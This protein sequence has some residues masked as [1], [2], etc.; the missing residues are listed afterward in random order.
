M[1]K[2]ANNN[3]PHSEDI[4]DIISAPPSALLRWG[5]TGVFFV[6]LLIVGLSA[7]IRY[8]DIVQATVRISSVDAPKAVISKLSGTIV[9]LLVEENEKVAKG[10]ALAWL[11]STADHEQVITLLQELS[12][13]RDTHLVAK[14]R[15]T[16]P[17]NAPTFQN[18]GELQQ[19]YQ[20]FYQA[21]ISLQA[22]VEGGIL[23]KRKQYLHRDLSNIQAQRGQLAL[24]ENLQR[25]EL[26]LA[27]QE[28]SRYLKLVER[29]VISTSEFQKEQSVYLS[30]QHPLQQTHS[31]MLSNDAAYSAKMKE[32]HDLENQIM[33]EKA[34]YMQALN[35]LI[36]EME[37]WQNQYVLT[38]QQAGT[39]VFAGFLQQNQHV[40]TGQEVFYINSHGGGFFGE[41][42]IPQYN[43]GKVH[44]GQSVLIKLNSYPFEEYGILR[45]HVQQVNT[46]PTRDSVFLSKVTL[47]PKSLKHNIQ[48]KTGL[49]GSA[50]II[51][52]EASLLARL[53]RNIIK[54]AD[55]Q[56]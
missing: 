24:Q 7:F 45:G 9:N 35:S 16:A 13:L 11:E 2:I 1:D 4:E 5:I 42:T 3:Q 55:I 8:P 39:V 12:S 37:K 27:E 26:A 18:L 32:L 19:A 36:S 6:I 33:E 50:E 14:G 34:K 46:V 28:F 54:L 47:D 51:T 15:M 23:S 53:Y 49:L 17:V 52:E 43:L 40:T 22:A 38:A 56:Q 20:T 44:T 41:V 30:K 21:H 29:K 31:S 10:Q 25:E 48:L